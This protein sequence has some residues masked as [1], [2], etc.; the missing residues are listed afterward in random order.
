MCKLAKKKHDEAVAQVYEFL[1]NL[2]G[3]DPQAQW[4]WICREMHEHDSWA[5]LTGTKNEGKRPHTWASFKDCL[6]LHKLTVFMIDVAKCLKFYIQ[7][8]VRK[9]QRA[10]IRQYASRMEVLNGYLRHLPML[11]NSPKAVTTTKKGNIPFAEADLA[12]IIPHNNHKSIW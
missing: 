7:Q 3:G 12:S 11:K 6:G 1:H 10:T 5:S 9:P 2:L 8:G 4:D